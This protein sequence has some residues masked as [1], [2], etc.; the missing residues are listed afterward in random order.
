MLLVKG[1]FTVKLQSVRKSNCTQ[2]RQCKPFCAPLVLCHAYFS[3][4]RFY[5]G[6]MSVKLLP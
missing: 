2:P 6:M 1:I 3:F 5:A 4:V